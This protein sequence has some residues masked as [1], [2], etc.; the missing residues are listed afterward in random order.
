M[1]AARRILLADRDL[2]PGPVPKEALAYWRQKGLQVGFDYRDVWAEEHDY[3]FTAAKVMR[4]D[5]LE[6]LQEHLDKSL[7]EGLPFADFVKSVRPELESKGWWGEHEVTD[8]VTGRVAV[9]KPPR[10][11]AL[12][13][14]TNMR[15]ARAAGQYSRIQAEK[16][17]RPYLL[18]TIGPSANHRE[19]HVAWHGLLLPADDPF[20]TY[21]FPPNGYGCKCGVRSVSKREYS[22]LKKEG[23]VEGEP[24]P[25]LD[26][27]GLP[28]G[29]VV[30]KR[31]PVI[32]KAPS[33]PLVPWTNK[34]TGQ[35]ILVREGI[36]P[37]F[38]RVPTIGRGPKPAPPAPTP[39]TPPPKPK[40]TRKP[41]AA[42]TPKVATVPPPAPAPAPALEPLHDPKAHVVTYKRRGYGDASAH[43]VA[44]GRAM[45]ERGRDVK[46]ADAHTKILDLSSRGLKTSRYGRESALVNEAIAYGVKRG[47]SQ[48][49][50]LGEALDLLLEDKPFW[51]APDRE[52]HDRLHAWSAF[53]G[54]HD[55]VTVRTAPLPY[56]MTSFAGM[57]RA[58]KAAKEA[59]ADR[60]DKGL[61]LYR[62]LADETVH[63]EPGYT[64][65][66]DP[67]RG[68]HNG[69]TKVISTGRA[70]EFAHEVAHSLELWQTV[71]GERAR[72]FLDSRTK[73]EAAQSLRKLTGKNYKADEKAKPDKFIEAY[74]GKIYAGGSTEVTTMGVEYIAEGTAQNIVE[75]DVELLY[76]I[77]GQLS[78]TKASP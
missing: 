61:D 55:A 41:K 73:G 76:F 43:A 64:C 3:A 67:K 15:M 52:L 12:I 70:E 9:V 60:M 66:Y 78:G 49:S 44:W 54:H 21:A 10:R 24:E 25:V 40:R 33:V 8:P 1:T 18:Y 37:G 42:P 75:K 71:L 59:V 4:T 46:L 27:N 14:D 34:R 16:A 62:V 47:L 13:Y 63:F 28:T 23:V 74:M 11:L 69:A 2:V 72:D 5:V 45:H 58:S 17:F 22:E 19:E 36:D 26:D 7:A 29:H 6:A 77:L 57:S 39:V 38:D 50:T 68:F 32:L 31:V 48:E 53:I 65:K 20:W 35:T 30:E 56:R 51:S